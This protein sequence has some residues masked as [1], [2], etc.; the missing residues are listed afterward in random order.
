LECKGFLMWCLTLR[1][2]GFMDY[3]RRPVFQMK[4]KRF[5]KVDL[6]LSAREDKETPILLVPLGRS[7]MK[8]SSFRN[9]GGFNYLEF[10][11]MDKV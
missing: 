1:I 5:G 10:Q 4:I 11:T 9:F 2:T 7:N 8:R 6:F 3:I